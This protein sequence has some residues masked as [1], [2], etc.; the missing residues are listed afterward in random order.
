MKKVLVLN[1]SPRGRSSASLK[2]AEAFLEGYT[3]AVEAEVE[4]IDLATKNIKPC[5]GCYCCWKSG[6]GT[7][8]QNDDMGAILPSYA[9]ADLVLINTPVYHFGMTAILKA[10]FER[11]L[12]MVYPY[13]VKKGELYA[14]PER[15]PVN[16]QQAIGLFATCG[17]PDADNF[18]VLG[19]HAE[20]LFGSRLRFR[21]FCPEGEL[22]KVPQ[23]REAAAPR[24]TA[25]REAGE[26]FARTGLVPAGAE[27]ALA[28]PMVDLPTFVRLA[29]ASWAVPGEAPP[30][31]TALAGLE[32]YAPAL[33]AAAASPLEVGLEG[34]SEAFLFLKRMSSLYNAEAG[35]GLKA[36]VQ[37]DFSDT[38]ETFQL[39][40][41][42]GKCSLE[43]GC[44][45]A[46][47]TRIIVPF[48]TWEGI[49]SGRIDGVEALMG[50]AYRV[51]GDFGLMSRF[52]SL[53][54]PPK[55]VERRRPNLMALA[56][57]PWYC[58]WFLGWNFW[59]GQALP[60]VLGLGFLVW[61]ESRKEATWFERGTA[62]AFAFL[63][64]LA[65]AAPAT[66]HGMQ[67]V[68]CNTA[69]AL[70]WASSLL[71]GRPLTSEYSRL[72]MS[73]KIAASGIFRKINMQLTAL[74]AVLFGLCAAAGLCFA[75]VGQGGISIITGVALIP[76]G[77]FTAWYPKWYPGHLARRGARR[78]QKES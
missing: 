63:V 74:W 49:S 2:L 51:E 60:L 59:L 56:F 19:A 27:A 16:P 33:S 78:V 45:A 7:C 53:F 32:P 30:T 66:F 55:P 12:P 38:G 70:I 26:A 37:F 54:E 22:L 61:R 1:G 4:T 28:S 40:I 52:G 69:I 10:F 68:F 57:V 18:R 39:A 8:V 65:L 21:F 36:V 72:S 67:S 15:A 46:P 43:Q 76:A 73:N 75:D 25:L 71:Y 11:S 17:F 35:A 64:A 20:K 44:P 6:S 24:L 3:K 13:M 48:A 77:F 42:E 41:A 9:G 5:L 14:H 23:M 47:T 58:G 62:L 29:N 31:E 50:G 34:P